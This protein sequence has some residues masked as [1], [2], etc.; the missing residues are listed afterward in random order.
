MKKSYA[1]SKEQKSIFDSKE[2]RKKNAKHSKDQYN[3]TRILLIPTSTKNLVE[4]PALRWS[5]RIW[6]KIH[7][8]TF[9]YIYSPPL[10]SST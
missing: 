1:N 7:T 3:S 10:Q 5:Q 8:A 6:Y 4:Y 9:V 2:G